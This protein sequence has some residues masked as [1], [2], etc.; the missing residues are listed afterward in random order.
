MHYEILEENM[1]TYKIELKKTN[2]K[3]FVY[4]LDRKNLFKILNDLNILDE[5]IF[6][7]RRKNINILWDVNSYD[8]EDM[9][10]FGN[11]PSYAQIY[12]TVYETLQSEKKAC[13]YAEWESARDEYV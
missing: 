6:S 1:E 8:M 4:T 12:P 9:A 11:K 10:I 2:S 5:S 3:I 13:L 7:I